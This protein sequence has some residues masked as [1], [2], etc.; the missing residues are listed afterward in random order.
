MLIMFGLIQGFAN[1][2]GVFL[3]NRDSLLCPAMGRRRPLRRCGNAERF[4]W[5]KH[6]AI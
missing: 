5:P 2:F 1:V 3:E 4:P 6:E